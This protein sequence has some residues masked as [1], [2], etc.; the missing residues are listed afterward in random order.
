MNQL[1]RRLD[2]RQTGDVLG[3]STACGTTRTPSISGANRAGQAFF[4]T[5]V[6]ALV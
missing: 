3:H 4:Y 1:S 2:A 6:N 5:G